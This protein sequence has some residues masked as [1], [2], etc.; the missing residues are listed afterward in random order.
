MN[1]TGNGEAKEPICMTHGHELRAGGVAQ[2]TGRREGAGRREIKGRKKWDNCNSIT[3][4]IHFKKRKFQMK[5]VA[6][7][8]C[9]C[10]AHYYAATEI[11]ITSGG[12]EGAV[13]RRQH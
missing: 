12:G 9:A 7:V 13:I 5:L 4:E 8:K 2:D 11:R 3:N 6:I 1:S 10:G